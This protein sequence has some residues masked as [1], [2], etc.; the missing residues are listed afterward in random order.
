MDDAQLRS[1][2][3][4]LAAT[5]AGRF[6]IEQV[7]FLARL[8]DQSSATHEVEDVENAAR[9]LDDAAKE[10]GLSLRTCADPSG[11]FAPHRVYT[12][13]AAGDG[14]AIAL[15]GHID[16]VFPRAMGFSGF[17]REGDV[18]RGPGVLDMKSG[19]SAIVFA[20]HALQSNARPLYEALRLRVVVVS[21]EEVGSSASRALY[22]ELAPKTTAALVFEHGRREDAIVT[23]RK[24]T[25]TF[26]ATARG[27]AAHAGL[28][29]EEG[30]SA[31]VALARLV[32]RIEELTDYER[33]V[34][35]NVGLIEG[36]TSKNTV[37]ALAR[38]TIDVRFEHPEDGAVLQGSLEDAIAQTA[39]TGRAHGATL[40]VA[41]EITRPPMVPTDASRALM[42]AYATEAEA[43]GLGGS[44]APLQ[45]GGSD[46]NLLAAM[47]V[48]C[49][50][51]LGPYGSGA[52]QTSEQCSLASLER[53]T[54]ALAR[55][56]ARAGDGS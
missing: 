32:D 34:T 8:V 53:R 15:V 23:A 48:P 2:D 43:V 7:P 55:F 3:E 13:P 31:I 14:P 42:R 54:L 25:A 21:D 27:T 28:A 4:A 22:E 47:G 16:T 9:L 18:A 12:T 40:T 17:T 35:Y 26:V 50:D 19:L 29:H 45:G 5:I 11:R 38:A 33:G 30:V 37:P 56:L 46:A 41:G 24:G 51:G 52:H 6:E 10:L 44:E 36:G 49:I 39:L 1:L 20:L